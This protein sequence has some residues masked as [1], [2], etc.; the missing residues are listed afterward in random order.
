MRVIA[1][2][3][4]IGLSVMPKTLFCQKRTEESIF[5][6]KPPLGFYTRKVILFLAEENTGITACEYGIGSPYGGDTH[7][8]RHYKSTSLQDSIIHNYYLLPVARGQQ[9]DFNLP[10]EIHVTANAGTFL[11]IAYD[12]NGTKEFKIKGE[13]YF[14]TGKQVD[15]I[16]VQAGDLTITGGPE[17]SLNIFN[18]GEEQFQ[19]VSLAKG[20]ANIL[21]K[22]Q[23]IQLN[24]DGNEGWRPYKSD[25]VFVRHHPT[26]EIQA[27]V[28]GQQ[29][30]MHIDLDYQLRSLSRWYN[31]AII[32]GKNDV[33]NGK[34]INFPYRTS[35][36][37][38]MIKNYSFAN[39]DLDFSLE[40]RAII[41][42]TKRN[43]F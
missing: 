35:T 30:Q 32:Y 39:P 27:W 22:G 37:Q 34:P 24:A 16:T 31:I 26:A 11:E 12:S 21:Y 2:I 10:G 42:R 7:T 4:V 40:E 5:P 20:L 36:V 15:S 41:V 19:V 28:K 14:Q 8:L 9:F 43:N 25:E 38:E 33:Q 1:I 29:R 23:K 17:S 3:V 13:A 6:K 18:Y